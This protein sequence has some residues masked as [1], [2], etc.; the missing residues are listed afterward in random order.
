V[1]RGARAA[2]PVGVSEPVAA[3]AL[4]GFPQCAGRPTGEAEIHVAARRAAPVDVQCEEIGAEWLLARIVHEFKDRGAFV[5]LV[6]HCRVQHLRAR[7]DRI[8]DLALVE[9]PAPPGHDVQR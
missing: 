7:L 5:D 9:R 2:I 4:P 8:V 1:R 6:E 3:R